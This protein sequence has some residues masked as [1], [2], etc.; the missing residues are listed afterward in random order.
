MNSVNFNFLFFFWCMLKSLRLY[1]TLC[2][3]VNCN[4]PGSS[5]HGN[6]QA[7]ILEWVAMPSSRGSSWPRDRTCISYVCQHWQVCGFFTTSATWEAP[8]FL[9][10]YIYIYIYVMHHDFV[11][12]QFNLVELD[13]CMGL[14]WASQVVLVIKNPPANA[15]SCKR[16]R[17]DPWVRKIPLME[18][19]A[20]HSS[21]LAKRIPWTEEPGWL[22]S[23]GSQRVRHD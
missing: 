2:D 9:W 7:W 10:F 22:P 12:P 4:P 14:F 13:I 8:L 18:G 17:F 21:I 16:C 6:L 23:I 1:L 11:P 20:I 5:V 19:M 3:P 15:G